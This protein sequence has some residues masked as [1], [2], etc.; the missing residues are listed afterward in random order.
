MSAGYASIARTD[1]PMATTALNIMQR[2]GGPTLTTA[3]ATFLG[4]RLVAVGEPRLTSTAFAEVFGLL[5]AFHGALLLATRF[6][7]P[8]ENKRS[9]DH[10]DLTGL[11]DTPG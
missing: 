7:K 10:P 1:I 9:Q 8:S 6:I 4:W 5:A 3:C 2:I 11:R